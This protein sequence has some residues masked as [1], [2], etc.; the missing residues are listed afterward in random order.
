MRNSQTER[1]QGG[2]GQVQGADLVWIPIMVKI[3]QWDDQ[4]HVNTDQQVGA[5]KEFE[6]FFRWN[7]VVIFFPKLSCLLEK[8]NEMFTD[9][10]IWGL[11]SAPQY[12]GIGVGL[13]EGRGRG[14]VRLATSWSKLKLAGV[15]GVHEGSLHHALYFHKILLTFHFK[16][17]KVNETSQ[18]ETSTPSRK[19][20]LWVPLSHKD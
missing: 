11:R 7:K 14:A 20:I 8:T 13:A 17:M 4:Q 5:T 9:E 12:S 16:K 15:G 1:D 10:L 18:K 3:S 6:V 19:G 2:I